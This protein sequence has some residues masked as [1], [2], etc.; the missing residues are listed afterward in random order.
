MSTKAKKERKPILRLGELNADTIS[1]KELAAELR[2]AKRVV[3]EKKSDVEKIKNLKSQVFNFFRQLKKSGERIE[4]RLPQI[5]MKRIKKLFID[6]VAADAIKN[7]RV[8]ENAVKK[9]AKNTEQNERAAII[10]SSIIEVFPFMSRELYLDAKL[11]VEEMDSLEF[12]LKHLEELASS[13]PFPLIVGSEH[14]MKV[15]SRKARN[16][17]K[18][19]PYFVHTSQFVFPTMNKDGQYSRSLWNL[20]CEKANHP[21]AKLPS[22]KRTGTNRNNRSN[23]KL[24]KA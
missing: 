10:L 1:N 24:V 2:A 18:P 7:F 17:K 4:K 20:I 23:K 3:P 14:D 6:K 21:K 16:L 5:K 15:A 13:Y 12:G 22:K 9:L 8:L 11:A 19:L